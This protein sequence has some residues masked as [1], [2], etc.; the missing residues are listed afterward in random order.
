MTRRLLNLLTALSLLLS[1]AVCVLWLRSHRHIDRLSG[2]LGAGE[3]SVAAARGRLYCYHSPDPDRRFAPG[4]DSLPVG[5]QRS[6]RGQTQRVG[7]K[8]DRDVLP[9]GRDDVRP[10]GLGFAAVRGKCSPCVIDV[11]DHSVDPPRHQT[12]MAGAGPSPPRSVARYR[13]H[14]GLIVPMWATA[15]LCAAV[16]VPSLLFALRS[17]RRFRIGL[18]PRCG[19]DLRASPG[20]CPECGDQPVAHAIEWRHRLSG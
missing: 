11:V 2:S 10:L 12:M 8:G 16:P 6:P 9:G 17:R 7:V 20:R 5:F 18:C 3:W 1:V 19:Y 15:A 4:L 14:R 13:R